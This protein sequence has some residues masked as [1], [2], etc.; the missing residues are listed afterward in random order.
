[1]SP[2][3]SPGR[4]RRRPRRGIWLFPGLPAAALVDSVVAAED[5]GLDEVWIADEGVARDPIAILA[6]AASK[7]TRIRLATGITSPVLRH[8]GAIASSIATVDELS[9]GRALLGLGVGGAMSLEPFG[10]TAVRPVGMMRDA[11]DVIRSVHRGVESRGY[12]PP[13]HA[14]PNR[15]IPIWVGA[16]GPQLVRLAARLADGLFVSGYSPDELE[17][18]LANA[19]TIGPVDIALYQ[20]AVTSPTRPNESSWDAVA[21]SLAEQSVAFA[22]ASIGLNL[23]QFAE[24]GCDPIRLIE[25]A[26]ALLQST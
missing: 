6:A 13:A 20:T 22:P 3:A 16:R 18:I 24:P 12:T 25:R 11:I 7:T 19:A 15:S 10:L 5:L 1:M 9:V 23:V 21:S 8:P 2:D 14:A 26:A 4:E 17:S